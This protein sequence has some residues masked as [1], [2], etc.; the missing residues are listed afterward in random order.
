MRSETLEIP[1]YAGPSVERTDAFD[2]APNAVLRRLNS[3]LKP[4]CNVNPKI[5]HFIYL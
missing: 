1:T 5:C 4:S 2:I 3:N